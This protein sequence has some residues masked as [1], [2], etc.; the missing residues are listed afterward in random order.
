MCFLRTICQN[1]HAVVEEMPTVETSVVKGH[2]ETKGG[3]EI[4]NWLLQD[5][6]VFHPQSYLSLSILMNQMMANSASLVKL[7]KVCT[8][9]LR[10]STIRK[11]CWTR[12]SMTLMTCKMR[13]S[14]ECN[15]RPGDPRTGSSTKYLVQRSISTN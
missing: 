2:E 4:G 7:G 14:P 1:T 9:S 12:L 10:V 3:Y 5:E 15:P 11:L 13:R 6:P 8:Q